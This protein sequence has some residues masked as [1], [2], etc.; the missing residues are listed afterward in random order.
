MAFEQQ[1]VLAP[2]NRLETFESKVT[3]TVFESLMSQHFMSVELYKRWVHQPY[4][5]L[6][7][8]QISMIINLAKL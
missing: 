3:I 4:M 1:V 6:R 8:I 5:D 7:V 2:R